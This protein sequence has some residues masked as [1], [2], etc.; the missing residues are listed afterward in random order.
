VAASEQMIAKAISIKLTGGK[1]GG[2]ASKAV[3]L[4]RRICGVSRNRDWR[5]KRFIL[6]GSAEVS[7]GQSGHAVG[8]PLLANFS[9][10]MR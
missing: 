5:M 1:S 3:D 6:T 10:I 7:K 8:S 4:P 9:C 2:C